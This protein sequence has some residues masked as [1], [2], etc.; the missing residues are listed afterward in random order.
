MVTIAW[1][2][3]QRR[4]AL[5][6]SLLKAPHARQLYHHALDLVKRIQWQS[7][8][9]VPN[10]PAL[11]G[12]PHMEELLLSLLPWIEEASALT[13]YPTYSYL[14]VY[15]HGDVLARHRDRAA[16]EISVSLSL[17]YDAETPWPLWIE[18]PTG[19][20]S[21]LMEPGDG[22]LYRGTECF[23]WRDAFSGEQ[24]AQVFLHYVDQNG[25]NAEWKFDK[26][27]G[28]RI[29]DSLPRLH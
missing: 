6:C 26:R 16:C 9:Q 1:Q 11:Y 13:L 22:L 14:R 2:F 29:S 15:K 27:K 21:V 3:S 18:G 20:S 8:E 7:D 5:L 10:T 24:A 19:V 23:H 17:G 4:Y 28:C 25:L 12:E